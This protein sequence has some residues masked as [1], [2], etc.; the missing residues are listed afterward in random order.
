MKFATAL[1]FG[2]P[3]HFTAMART[4][5]QAGWDWF[6]IS[7]HVLFPETLESSYPYVEGG[8]P[9]WDAEAAW[10]DPIVAIAAMAAVTEKLR[11]M[12]NVYILPARNPLLVAKAVGTAAVMSGGRISLGVGTGWMR[13]EFEM[14]GQRFER[15]GKRTN[16][17]IEVL[18]AL[19]HTG[20]A[21]FH[22]E[23][24]DFEPVRMF[25]VPSAPI[26]IYVGG[27]SEPAL[28]RAARL[29]DGW[30]AVQHTT[31]EIAGY[32][33]KINEYRKEYG[34]EA[35]PFEFVVAATD[36]F[37]VDAY[38][39]LEDVGAT[40]LITVPWLF[41]G[42]DADSLADKQSGL[43]RFAEDVIHKMR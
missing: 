40:T 37:D 38:K 35:E 9:Y 10:P 27:L 21:E 17:C 4:A 18:R 12:T 34:R 30:I 24:Y 2:A 33:A 32:V 19:W 5:D 25:P 43:E 1:A 6:A 31:D 16:E 22:G 11:F 39:R 14:L 42:G 8:K 41:Y 15:R 36:A 29:G 20:R 26:P 7:D 3:E 23:F 13:E 28:R